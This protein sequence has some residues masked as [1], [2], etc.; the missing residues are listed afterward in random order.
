MPARK[1]ITTPPLSRL[2]TTAEAVA[3]TDFSART[4]HRWADR[5][6]LTKYYIGT[7]LRWDA[8][9]LDALVTAVKPDAAVK[10]AERLAA[11]REAGAA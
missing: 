11:R 8:A 7:R 9:E 4:L 1:K 5:R 6:Q 10:S 2:L 3:A